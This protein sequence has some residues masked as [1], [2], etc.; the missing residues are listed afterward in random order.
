MVERACEHS[1]AVRASTCA[2]GLCARTMAASMVPGT[3]S[4]GAG[5]GGEGAGRGGGATL[6]AAGLISP[7]G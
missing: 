6:R 2:R 1:C 4:S 5:W 7:L 3:C